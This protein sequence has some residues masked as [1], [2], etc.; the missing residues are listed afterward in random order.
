M[1]MRRL[2]ALLWLALTVLTLSVGATVVAAQTV[3]SSSD[4][5]KSVTIQELKATTSLVSG[6]VANHSPHAIRN[7]EILVQYHWLWQSEFKPGPQSPGQAALIRVD[8]D[9]QPGQSVA[10]RYTP[11]PPLPERR[12]GRFEPEVTI[13]GFTVVVPAP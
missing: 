10:F 9:V 7:I 2:H 12:D 5:A 13:A 4:A 3:L 11:A 1:S 6:V 8:K